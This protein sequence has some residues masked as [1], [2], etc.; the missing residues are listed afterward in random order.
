MNEGSDSASTEAYALEARRKSEGSWLGRLVFLVVGSSLFA[1]KFAGIGN[2][3]EW[4][5]LGDFQ[6][7]WT[8]VHWEQW[9]QLGI[10]A[11]ESTAAAAVV[12]IAFTYVI[13]NTTFNSTVVQ[14]SEHLEGA[15]G[16]IR[17]KVS[18]FASKLDAKTAADPDDIKLLRDFLTYAQNQDNAQLRER[19][20]LDDELFGR[21]VGVIQEAVDARRASS[22]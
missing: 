4:A 17:E 21:L 2:Q 16:D 8:E 12:T 10:L 20:R 19:L 9:R 22:S 7:H 11:L 6:R 13:V 3:V 5:F 14:A 1:L 18:S 15:I